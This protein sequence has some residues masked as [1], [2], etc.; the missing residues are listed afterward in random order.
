[1][2]NQ[3]MD[4]VN[5]A[6][7]QKDRK[8][9]KDKKIISLPAEHNQPG[10]AL[11]E[12]IRVAQI[13]VGLLKMVANFIVSILKIQNFQFMKVNINPKAV[14]YQFFLTTII[15]GTPITSPTAPEINYFKFIV[16]ET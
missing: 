9:V 7:L 4:S 13:I 2:N 11:G 8:N 10:A 1:M 15:R 12:V 5:S 6:T 14:F 3:Q 16:S